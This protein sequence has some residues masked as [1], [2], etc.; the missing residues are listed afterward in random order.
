MFAA[1]QL[2]AGCSLLI[3]ARSLESG[4]FGELSFALALQSYVSMLGGLGLRSLIVRDIARNED[5][6]PTY[7]RAHWRLLPWTGLV[8]G[9]LGWLF[10]TLSAPQES[11]PLTFFVLALGNWFSIVSPVAFQDGLRKQHI[12]ILFSLIAE[13]IFLVVLLVVQQQLLTICCLF[14]FKWTFTS[15]ASHFYVTSLVKSSR[16]ATT[17]FPYHLI[18]EATN[19]MFTNLCLSWPL[20]GV[21]IL[22][23]EDLDRTDFDSVGLS[24]QLATAFSQLST[25]SFR[26]VQTVVLSAESLKSSVVRKQV[27]RIVALLL[28]K[29]AF[30]SAASNW[31]V[32][33]YLPSS[34]REDIWCINIFLLAGL[35]A[36]V[37]YVLMAC[38]VACHASRQILFSYLSGCLLFTAIYYCVTPD[39]VS[40]ASFLA[41]LSCTS[42]SLIMIL[43]CWQ[44][45]RQTITTSTIE[46]KL[47]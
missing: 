31:V 42:L 5:N 25:I 39:R 43:M 36:G 26:Q 2:L 13:T 11:I 20:A 45:L 38:L 17:S 37:N 35:I 10:W 33:V 14:A 21:L 47:S 44:T 34:Y 8:A 28:L 6:I 4:E 22:G 46:E 1:C 15:I 16:K 19:L 7:L 18:P 30:L 41:A 27:L 3:I 12:S 9:L 24:V 40:E 23:G 29:W 32:Q